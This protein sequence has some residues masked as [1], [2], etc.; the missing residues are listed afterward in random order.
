MPKVYIGP[1]HD[2]TG[3]VKV[4]PKDP[5]STVDFGFDFA[6]LGALFPGEKLTSATWIVPIGLTKVSEEFTQDFAKVWISGGTLGTTYTIT[7]RY[8]TTRVPFTDDRSMT[9]E[10]VEL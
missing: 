5:N 8:S 9:F 4:D 3:P 10:C 2:G 6:V 7:L 1:V